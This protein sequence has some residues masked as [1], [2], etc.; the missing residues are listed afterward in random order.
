VL[1][2]QTLGWHC[3]A[4]SVDK[5]LHLHTSARAVWYYWSNT[6]TERHG[7]ASLP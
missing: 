6:R 5:L 3:H 4:H 7:H 2:K 1:L